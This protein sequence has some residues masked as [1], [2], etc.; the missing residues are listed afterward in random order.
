MNTWYHVAVIYNLNTGSGSSATFYLNGTLKGSVTSGSV[1]TMTNGS[2]MIGD[3]I[4]SNPNPHPFAGYI[5]DY[6]IYS[7]SIT[8]D[9]IASLSNS[10]SSYPPTITSG[11]QI[12]LAFSGNALDSSGNNYSTVITGS[13]SYVSG[14]YAYLSG[15]LSYSNLSSYYPLDNSLSDAITSTTTNLTQ[16]GTVTFSN[17]GKVNQCASFSGAGSLT[18]SNST[19]NYNNIASGTLTCWVNYSGSG[20][21]IIGR[22]NENAGL[23]SLATYAFNVN[24]SSL[25]TDTSGNNYNLTNNGVTFNSSNYQ[26]GAGSASF[27]GSSYFEIANT[28][29]FSPN[30]FTI[31]FWCYIYSSSD[32]KTIAHCR[33]T[34]ALVGWIIYV[35]PAN[36]LEF[37]TGN[38]GG[39]WVTTVLAS[40]FGSATPSWKNIVISM[41]QS[42]STMIAYLNGT[43]LGTYTMGYT[44]NNNGTFRI[45]AGDNAGAPFYYLPNGSLLNNFQMYSSVYSY[46][47]INAV[48]KNSYGVLSLGSYLTSGSPYY[49]TGTSGKVYFWGSNTSSTTA[50]STSTLSSGTWYHIAVVFS[51]SSCLIYIN[52]VLDSTTSG[53][54]SIP[55]D[56]STTYSGIGDHMISTTHNYYTGLIDDI[57]IWNVNLS[58]SVITSLYYYQSNIINTNSYPVSWT[59]LGTTLF[60]TSGYGSSSLVISSNT[61]AYSTNSG[62][63]WTGLGSTIFTIQGL[64]MCY[65]NSLYIATGQGS[66]NTL[67]YSSNASTWT[68]LG[69]TIFNLSGN[70]VAWSSTLTLFVAVGMGA[71]NT[72]AYSA[73]GTQWTGLGTTVF[74][75]QGLGV[76][77]S[78]NYFVANGYG[79]N[80]ISYSSNGTVWTG[81]GTTAFALSG[82][83]S[84]SNILNVSSNTLAYS[85][86]GGTTWTGLGSSIFLQT[87]GIAYGNSRWVATGQGFSNTLA[88]SSN[89]STWSGL[90]TTIFSNCGND[91]AYNNYM[92]VAVGTGSA[93]T[94]AYSING[95]Q[96]TGLG[97]TILTGS[98]QSVSWVGLYFIASGNGTNNVAYSSNGFIWT[99]LNS[100][101]FTYLDRVSYNYASTGNTL[102]YSTGGSVTSWTGLGNSIFN[103]QTNGLAYGNSL[104]IATGQGSTNTLAYSSNGT[105]WTGLGTSIIGFSGNSVAWSSTLSL[106]VAVG[107][108]LTNS[109]AYSAN[110]TQWTGL[111]TT[112]FTIAG[113]GVNWSGFYFIASGYGGSNT[114]SYSSNGTI[115]T[116][117]GTTIF[118]T[119]G[120][121]VSEQLVLN[122]TLLYSSTNGTTWTGLSYTVLLQVNGLCY[123][124]S[125]FVAIG[126]GPKG[127]IASSTDGTTWTNSALTLF[128]VVCNGIASNNFIFVA[129]GT[130]ALNS[131]AYSYNGTQWTGL[132]MTIFSTQ[133][134]AVS[135]N[136]LY[137][138]ASGQ[139]TNTTSYSS[140]GLTWTGLGTTSFTTAGF[141]ASYVSTSSASG[142]SS[143]TLAYSTTG[144]TTWTGLASSIFSIQG[145]GIVYGNSL[146]VATGQ[147][148]LNTLAYSS[149]SSTWTGLGVAIFGTSGNGVAYSS[150]LTL[151]VAVG[152]G[153]LNSIA[154]SAN[155]T[156]W[157]GLG[158]SIFS[159]KGNG[160]SWSTLYFIATGYGTNTVAY[161]SNGTVWTGLGVTIFSSIGVN[162]ASQVIDS[163]TLAYSTNNGTTWT[164]LGYS[165]FNY[166]TNGVSYRTGIWVA[167]GKGTSHTIAYSIG[168]TTTWVGVGTSIF[169]VQGNGVANTGLLFVAVGQGSGNTI[170]Y[171]GTGTIW[172]GVGMSVFSISGQSIYYSG[173]YFIAGG[174]S[175]ANRAFFY[176]NTGIV[177]SQDG[178]TF[179]S[180]TN[181]N[182]GFSTPDIVRLNYG[183]GYFLMCSRAVSTAFYYSSDGINWTSVPNTSYGSYAPYC[184]IYANSKYYLLVY[185]NTSV[186]FALYTSTN[187]SS[188]TR[189]TPFGPSPFISNIIFYNNTFYAFGSDYPSIS[190][191]YTSAD[192][193]ISGFNS[194]V[195]GSYSSLRAIGVS[196]VVN[197]ILYCFVEYGY[198]A[199]LGTDL[200]YSTGAA[201]TKV[202]V[203]TTAQSTS[204]AFTF[205]NSTYVLLYT[206]YGSQYISTSATLGSLSTG[207]IFSAGTLYH[208]NFVFNKFYGIGKTSAVNQLITYSTDGVTWTIVSN[209]PT[210]FTTGYII[211]PQTLPIN[212]TIAYSVNGIDWSSLITPPFYTLGSGT[213]SRSQASAGN[214]LAYSTS[215]GTTWT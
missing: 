35:T 65:G 175:P 36:N 204:N 18:F 53:N 212:N 51:A 10:S 185:E 42:T 83:F 173:I 124:N 86:T 148:T 71:V 160:V 23:P 22:R 3:S 102:A 169:S 58:S 17:S 19:S 116:G 15:G 39:T 45:G 100:T 214:T 153:Y 60:S 156:Q 146:W 197:N 88:Y 207:V 198:S 13:L 6:R 187:L 181:N 44:R 128:S 21:P 24:L 40:N 119:L 208:I 215:N 104:Y 123:G 140:D 14:Q 133:G 145:N 176:G 89:G 209:A 25:P 4:S 109:V 193:T 49:N 29:Q 59:G 72:M 147:G 97:T 157:T 82:N 84:T 101:T 76:S 73:N 33:G 178:L 110:G 135:W 163:N 205:G 166:Q 184:C 195:L 55:N 7:R 206:I 161:S 115:W 127:N 91:I 96:W 201:F 8:T 171:S 62:T 144:G 63:T 130:G 38:N 151:F 188:W 92:F 69:T 186:I 199:P 11:L 177:I 30:N 125:K 194:Q 180:T 98:G 174:T 170:A 64:G 9:E 2:I 66:T 94:I 168:N 191:S 129:V 75:Y 48:N 79:T 210:A 95:T 117:L 134:N 142:I 41:S 111:G 143:N 68:G 118:S 87:N 167:V 155:G 80:S 78:G 70:S 196:G 203:I 126:F 106:F 159:T 52:G 27:N 190:Y 137:F 47:Q 46:A 32:Y 164:G 141:G 50:V 132:G 31:S 12:Y 103:Y 16:S 81:V 57:G 90:G 200:Y 93:N 183:N 1:I 37:W 165:I 154:Y 158:T 189:Y 85:T 213:S 43:L 211:A 162:S 108:C 28:G 139:G 56:Q 113:Y 152:Q 77:W 182:P 149:N 26:T 107:Q 120:T 67:A 138:I 5:Q 20:G 202:S 54:Y 105:T 179:D 61:M 172:T 192:P 112:I 121:S 122:N 74:A 34:S 114:I 99:G 150:S 131:V 136:G